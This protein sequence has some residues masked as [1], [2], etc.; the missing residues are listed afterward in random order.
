MAV[1]LNYVALPLDVV[2][3]FC[4]LAEV[5]EQPLKNKEDEAGGDGQQDVSFGHVELSVL[6]ECQEVAFAILHLGDDHVDA[7]QASHSPHESLAS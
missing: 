6:L 3:Q 4:V 7:L 5:V 1:L 2:L